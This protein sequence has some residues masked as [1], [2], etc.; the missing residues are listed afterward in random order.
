MKFPNI[1]N[2]K[3]GRGQKKETPIKENMDSY[4]SAGTG[5]VYKDPQYEKRAYIDISTMYDMSSLL[6]KYIRTIVN[7]CLRYPLKAKPI[8]GKEKD[9]RAIEELLKLI[10]Y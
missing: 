8:K 2:F 1:F 6:K 5:E 7:D 3:K 9:S 10:S 4:S